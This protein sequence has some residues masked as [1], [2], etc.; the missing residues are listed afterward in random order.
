[1][2]GF[3]AGQCMDDPPTPWVPE[4]PTGHKVAV[5]GAGPAGLTAAYYLALK[6]HYCKVFDM[7]PQPGGMLRYDIPEYPRQ[8]DM[9]DKEFE[10]VWRLGVDAQYN[11]KLGADFTLDDLLNQGFQAIFIAT[12]ERPSN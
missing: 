7:M 8:K 3:A 6:G 5:V 4:A 1:M 10:G 11:V 9:I 12:G 2:H